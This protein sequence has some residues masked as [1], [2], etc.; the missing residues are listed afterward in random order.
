[1]AGTSILVRVAAPRLDWQHCQRFRKLMTDA[2]VWSS[3]PVRR[4]L[5]RA[6]VFL[7]ARLWRRV[8]ARHRDRRDWSDLD[9][10]HM[11]DL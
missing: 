6:P 10:H 8:R 2:L 11:M 4:C 3:A 9:A 1:M 5:F 7:V